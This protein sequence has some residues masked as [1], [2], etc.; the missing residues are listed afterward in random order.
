[1]AD[2]DVTARFR[3]DIGDLQ[4]KMKTVQT[5]LRNVQGQTERSAKGFTVLRGAVG[6]A[7]GGAAIGAFYSG[8]RALK[9]FAQGAVDAAVEARKADDRIEAI[10]KSMGILNSNLGGSTKRITDFASELQN[11][12][13]VSDEVIKQGQALILTFANVAAS[14]GE[15]GGMFDRATEAAIDLSAAGFG[16]VEGASRQLGKALQDPIKGITALSRSGVTFTEKEKEKIKALTESG[17]ILKAQEMIMSAVEMQVGG[18]AAATMTAGDKM[19]VAFDEFQEKLG[20]AI[21]PLVEKLQLFIAEKVIPALESFAQRAVLILQNLAPLIPLISSMTLAVIAGYAAFKLYS[22]VP[23]ILKAVSTGIKIVQLNMAALNIVILANPIVAVAAAIVAAVALIAVA[24]KLVYDRSKPLRDAI[25]GLVDTFKAIAS[26]IVKDVIGAFSSSGT[27]A[28]KL[29]KTG[30]SMGEIFDKVAGIIGDYL[31][32]VVEFLGKYFKILGNG[33]RVLIKYWEVLFKVAQMIVGLFK[34]GIIGVFNRV[35]FV[36]GAVLDKLGP[37]GAAFKRVGASIG[38]AFGNIS[39]IVKSAMSGATGFI[40]NAINTAIDAINF[41]IRAYNNIPLLSDISEVQ[42]FSMSVFEDSGGVGFDKEAAIAAEAARDANLAKRL[43]KP[44]KTLVAESGGDTGTDGGASKAEEERLKKIEEFV[45]GFEA[46]LERMK[47]GKDT[48]IAATA[49]PFSDILGDLA[50]SEIQAAF[51]VDGSIGAVISSFDQLGAAIDDFYKPL[52]NAKR[53]GQKAAADA[54]SLHTEAKGFLEDATRTALQLMKNREANKAALAKLETDY[55][56]TVSGLNRT[57]DELD[58]VAAANIKSIEDKFSAIIPALENALSAATAA[59]DKENS[60]LQSLIQARDG[61][62]GRINDGFRGF[63]NNLTI[64]KKQIVKEV[65]KAI[66]VVEM[67]R[68]IKDMGNGIR[69]T[70]EEQIKPAMTE[71]AESL[72]DQ[73]LTGGDVKAA[74]DERLNE[75]RSFAKNIKTLTSR[76]VDASLIQEFVAAGV[77]GA[78]EIAGALAV[79]SDEE[80]AGINAVQSA[81][82]SEIAGFQT[83]ATQQW[84]A[85]GIAQ[86]EAIVAPLAAA[87]DQAQ[88]A[89]NTANASRAAELT[90]AQAH[91]EA[92]RV[93]RQVALDAAK[94]QYEEQKAALILQGTEIDA[95]LTTNATNLHNS[96]ANLQNTVPPEMMKAGRKSVNAILAGFNEKFPGMKNAL[97]Q[98]MDNLAASMNRTATVTITT[99]QRTVFDSGAGPDGRR[100]LGGPVLSGKTY[101]V[102]E[103]GPE[104]LTMGAFSGN[105]I[106]NDRIGTVPNLSAGGGS[107]SGGVTNISI[108]VN[109]GMGTD[110]AEVGRQVVEAI[111]KYERRSGQVFVSV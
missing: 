8:A 101:L 20:G 22:A 41:L 46:A 32:P 51:G 7:L 40:E 37:L 96:I 70:I 74:L 86:Q 76:G 3:A 10:A 104:L 100:A 90:A 4:N 98:K 102:G 111:R 87:R 110:G 108:N 1:M 91:A 17:K 73:A 12:T 92:L 107:S 14:A 58:K 60:V 2:M 105:I 79:A 39:N 9:S 52:M 57:F 31:V 97:N 44:G 19:R 106:P 66:P 5:S 13:G 43:Q 83:Y 95:A 94:A 54:K 67:R 75:I 68:T 77:Q 65:E 62:L 18:T 25:S 109:A 59:F 78:G 89:L 48:L 81:L 26:V 30:E 53:F 16:S 45:K 88:A 82:A 33:I 69:V 28:N 84:F 71:L 34:V 27:A 64:N 80:I 50:P 47:R 63:L 11:T 35:S 56:E 103:R 23:G 99:V 85:A 21:L 36:I 29:G 42:A 38:A 6:T 55:S 93:Q 61:F 72:S 15:Q 49:R 24:L